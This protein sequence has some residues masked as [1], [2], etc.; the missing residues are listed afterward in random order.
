MVVAFSKIEGERL[1]GR[2]N[3]GSSIAA[4]L[5]I[6]RVIRSNVSGRGY[7]SARNGAANRSYVVPFDLVA[8]TDT[9]VEVTIPGDTSGTWTVDNTAG[10][11]VAWTFGVGSTFQTTANAWRVGNYT[12][13]SDCTNFFSTTGNKVWLGPMV[14]LTGLELPTFAEIMRCQR[15]QSDELNGCRRY[16]ESSYSIGVVPGTVTLVGATSM[17]TQATLSYH[18]LPAFVWTE[19]RTT[20]TATVYSPNTGATSKMWKQG[21]G[22]INSAITGV[23]TRGGTPFVN[24]VSVAASEGLYEHYKADAR[25]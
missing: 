7:C 20:P 22:D 13:A 15:H 8:N 9:W 24:G 5:K 4:P 19:K 3:W 18:S 14:V 11:I 23:G 16:W 10:L 6:G 1:R 25:M 2:L 21:V 12:G 17:V